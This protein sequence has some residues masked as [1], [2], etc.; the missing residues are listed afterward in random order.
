MPYQRLQIQI[1]ESVSN[2]CSSSAVWPWTSYLTPLCLISSAVRW[3]NLTELSGAFNQLIYRGLAHGYCL[4]NVSYYYFYLITTKKALSHGMPTM[5]QTVC[6]VQDAPD[7]YWIPLMGPGGREHHPWLIGEEREAQRL[8]E[9]HLANRVQ[10]PDLELRARSHRIPAIH[11][12]FP[13]PTQEE[14]LH[15]FMTCFPECTLASH[16]TAPGRGGR[17][18][19]YP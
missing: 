9:G 10:R 15:P 2:L 7:L 3:R 4:M 17:L 13:C 16:P 8:V 12:S 14:H 6:Q 1:P 5:S 19:H 11:H 18:C